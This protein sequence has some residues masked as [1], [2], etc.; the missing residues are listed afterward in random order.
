MEFNS[1]EPLYDKISLQQQSASATDSTSEPVMDFFWFFIPSY[2][3]L[4]L[5]TLRFCF[6][7]RATP[8]KSD[9][10][11]NLLGTLQILC[12][13]MS[14]TF[15]AQLAA[16]FLIKSTANASTSH[17]YLRILYL[18]PIISWML[19]F[20]L[21]SAEISR[22]ISPRRYNQFTFSC[23]SFISASTRLF[24]HLKVCKLLSEKFC[25]SIII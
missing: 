10:K 22:N 7:L 6:I 12:Y 14:L 9:I 11:P 13:V 2:I 25:L 1:P 15:C 23:L 5:G 4:F 8:S 21:T 3:F 16:D 17:K 18:C 20:H 19:S 24:F